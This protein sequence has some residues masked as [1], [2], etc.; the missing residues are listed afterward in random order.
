VRQV[1]QL[2]RITNIYVFYKN[3]Y[4]TLRVS[5]KLITNLKLLYSVS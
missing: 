1:G 3:L 5:V 2:P 4:E